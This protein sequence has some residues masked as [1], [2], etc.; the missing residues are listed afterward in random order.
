MKLVYWM[1]VELAHIGTLRVA[2]FFKNV[3]AIMHAPIGN[4]YYNVMHFMLEKEKDFTFV[5]TSIIDHHI[6]ACGFEEKIVDNILKKV[7]KNAQI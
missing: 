4:G 6:L 7:G 2:N 3:H 1:Y 5:T